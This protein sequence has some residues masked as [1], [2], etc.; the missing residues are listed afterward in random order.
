M[1]VGATP[2]HLMPRLGRWFR[3]VRGCLHAPD[4]WLV[5]ASILV[6]VA[7]MSLG[8]AALSQL[9]KSEWARA[10]QADA[11]SVSAIAADIAHSIELDD[12][13]LRAVVDDLA[14]PAVKQ[15]SPQLRQAILFEPNAIASHLGGILVLNES[16]YAIANSHDLRPR[17]NDYSHREYFRVHRDDPNVGLFIGRPFVTNSG[18]YVIALSR[19]LSHHDGS[20]AGVVVGI[21][22]LSYFEELFSRVS[23]GPDG[24]IGIY[25]TDGIL[26]ARFPFR[27]RDIG[28]NIGRNAQ[29]FQ[30]KTGNQYVTTAVTDGVKRLY[31]SRPIGDFPLVVAFG[32]SID[33][34]YAP[35]RKRAW[36]IGIMGMPLALGTIG[37]AAFA[38]AMIYRG[39]KCRWVRTLRAM[40]RLQFGPNLTSE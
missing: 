38:V 12:L 8:A 17:F 28:F 29:M 4:G 18:K 33:S 19:R 21:I 25:R 31:S 37:L 27:D 3:E 16:G 7:S 13:S 36:I 24:S 5:G 32:T 30:K 35:W 26:I 22:K 34:I 14:I 15:M 40:A 23:L 11:S 1:A 39:E 9:K 6:A 2:G 20:F 10:L